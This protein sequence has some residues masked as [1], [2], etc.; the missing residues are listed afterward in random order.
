MT[1]LYADKNLSEGDWKQQ[2]QGTLESTMWAVL[3]FLLQSR[4]PN[5]SQEE[6]AGASCAGGSPVQPFLHRAAQLLCGEAVYLK[7]KKGSTKA[8]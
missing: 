3:G 4:L 2:A 5:S 1:F 6:R 8:S 7:I